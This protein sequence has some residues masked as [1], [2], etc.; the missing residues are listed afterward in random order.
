ANVKSPRRLGETERI[1]LT[2]VSEA[3]PRRD[4]LALF[5]LDSRLDE[6]GRPALRITAERAAN[7]RRGARKIARSLRHER[8]LD[9][10]RIRPGLEV[11]RGIG[12]SERVVQAAAVVR[13]LTSCEAPVG[14]ERD[15]LAD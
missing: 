5:R 9:V 11:P 4:D 14:Q 15:R 2:C 10:R 1:Q 6:P 13:V 7:P 8:E 3:S 12:R